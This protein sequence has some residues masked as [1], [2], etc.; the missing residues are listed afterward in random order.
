M[1][2]QIEKEFKVLITKKQ[3]EYFIHE[4]YPHIL[5]IRQKNV[6]YDTKDAFLSKNKIAL[7]IRYINERKI[8]T[9][10]YYEGNDLMEIEKE[11]N[12]DNPFKDDFNIRETLKK[13]NI[14]DT[15][16]PCVTIVTYR[17][18]IAGEYAEIAID[19]NKFDD[20]SIDYEIE[21]E[22]KQPHNDIELFQSILDKI[23]IKYEKNAKSKIRRA[24]EK[25]D[26]K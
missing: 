7:R 26:K 25:R 1:H 3:Y 5:P 17:T 16:I 24:L 19:K 11:V 21:Y 14:V 20:G 22:V 8:V 15:L 4:M 6:Y 12:C 18:I 23:N 13:F 10:K 2:Q 9:L